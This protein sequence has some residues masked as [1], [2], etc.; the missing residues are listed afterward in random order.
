MQ[1]FPRLGMGVHL[2][3]TSGKPL[4]PC[5]ANCRARRRE[6]GYSSSWTSS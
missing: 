4:L 1:E 5:A 2:V 6:M 3:L